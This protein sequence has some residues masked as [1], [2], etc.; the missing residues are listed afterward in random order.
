MSERRGVSPC[1]IVLGVLAGVLL[2]WW[3]KARAIA[4]EAKRVAVM[5]VA[6]GSK[7]L[8]P[9]AER[10]D[11]FLTVKQLE[12]CLPLCGKSIRRE[13]AEGKLPSRRM[14]KKITVKG[15]DALAWLSAKK[16]GGFNAENA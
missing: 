7:R 11:E 12:E 2:G 9:L 1:W 15:S 6:Q 13:I 10:A 14:R 4:V 16:E 3:L 8:V 5:T